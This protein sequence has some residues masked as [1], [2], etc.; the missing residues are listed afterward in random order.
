MTPTALSVAGHR[1]STKQQQNI[2]LAQAHKRRVGSML[3]EFEKVLRKAQK[4]GNDKI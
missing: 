1:M 4:D 3:Q 2:S